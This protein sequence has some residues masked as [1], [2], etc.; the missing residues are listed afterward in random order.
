MNQ[1]GEHCTATTRKNEPCRAWSIRGRVPPLCSTHARHNTGAGAPAGNQ[2]A[3]KH[4]F[5]AT[6]L[7]E[8]ELADLVAYADDPPIDDALALTSVAL[9]RLMPYLRTMPEIPTP[10]DIQRL[11]AVA[12]LVF[13]GSNTLARLVTIR[14]SLGT[15]GL[16]SILAA[17]L[18][19][20][21]HELGVKL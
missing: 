14:K 2:N 17:A 21:S 7:T 16:E 18:D 20:L 5:Y 19:E 15:G 11:T 4:G 3:R 8:Q 6:V 10:E 1:T 12:G 9:R 13:T